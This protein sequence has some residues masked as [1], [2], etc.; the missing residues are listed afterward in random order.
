[1]NPL[2]LILMITGAITTVIALFY[3][4]K[5]PRN[6]FIR[7]T[8]MAVKPGAMS[9]NIVILSIITSVLLIL[10]GVF[11]NILFKFL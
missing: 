3:Y 6:L 10:L 7:R 8:D 2:L 9:F 11:P 5:I 4:I 1:H